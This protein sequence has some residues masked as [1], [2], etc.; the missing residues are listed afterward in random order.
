MEDELATP[1]VDELQQ[2]LEALTPALSAQRVLRPQDDEQRTCDERAGA[3]ECAESSL[4]MLRSC[5][6][7]C[8]LPKSQRFPLDLVSAMGSLDWGK[9]TGWHAELEQKL[10]RSRP[11]GKCRID[12]PNSNECINKKILIALQSC[13]TTPCNE[14]HHA[15]PLTG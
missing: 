2:K 10:R 7:S 5:A 13:P 8:G 6:A 12:D 4:A 15:K 11:A 3:G 9:R 14:A 1:G